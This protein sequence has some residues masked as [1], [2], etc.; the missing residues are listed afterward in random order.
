MHFSGLL[1]FLPILEAGASAVAAVGLR[2]I[3]KKKNL[4]SQRRV[5]YT[6]IVLVYCLDSIPSSG[7][8]FQKPDNTEEHSNKQQRL[9][10]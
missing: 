9:K 7:S 5:F 8:E 6:C 3:S 1:F 10:C 2:S 4:K